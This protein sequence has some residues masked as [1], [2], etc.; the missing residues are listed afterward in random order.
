MTLSLAG[1]WHYSVEDLPDFA[2]PGFSDS[3]WQTMR[4]P[5]NWFLGGLDHH[6]VVW[7][8]H[9]FNFKPSE[10]YTSLHFDGVDYFADV[11][12]NGSHLGHHTGYFERFSFDVTDLLRTGKNILAV[13]VNSPYEQLGQDG[14]HIRKRLIKGVLNHHDCRPGGG[15]NPDGQSYNTGGIWNN[16]YLEGH[17]A[18]T[19]E[20]V[21]LH[22]ELDVKPPVLH[23]KLTAKNRSGEQ[24]ADLEVHCAPENFKGNV[25]AS[26]FALEIPAGE[27]VHSVQLPIPDAQLWQ[28]WDRGYPHLYQITTTLTA[29]REKAVTTSLFGFRTVKLEQGFHWE[30]NG[31]PYFIRGSNYIGSQWLSET[32]FSEAATS[33]T[34]P[35]GGGAGGDF[36]RRDVELAR[37]ANLNMLRVHAHVLPP[38]FHDACDRAGI[39][40]W[41]D[42]PLQWGYSDQA[43]F[44][45]EAEREMRLMVTQLYNHPSIAAW[46]CHN[47]SP[48][49]APWMA[50]AVGGTYDP[51]QN[52]DLDTHLQAIAMELDP[53]RHVH[54]SSGTGDGHTYPG[55]YHGHWRD[56][57]D[58]P[59]APFI[60]EYGAQ[61]LPVKESLQRMLPQFESDA[62]FA[63]LLRLKSWIE[64]NKKISPSTRLFIKFGFALFKFMENRPS[65][66]RYRESFMEWAMKRGQTAERSIYQ[67]LPSLEEIPADLQPARQVWQAWQFHNT[68][69]METFENG[70]KTGTSLDDF[71]FN[72]QTYQAHVI[73]FGTECYRRAKCSKVTGI[74]QFDFTD[75]WP[76]VTW[77]VLDYWRHP[78]A[79]FDALRR[80]MQPVLPS[81]Q[82]PEKIDSGKAILASFCA[83]N[84]LVEAFP[85]TLCEWLLFNDKGDIASASFALD[86]PADGVSSVVKLTLPS[87]TLGKYTLSVSLTIGNRILGENW[88]EI[89]VDNLER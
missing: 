83:V 25:L 37:Q 2:N 68:Q 19:I 35:F 30:I 86:I 62:G 11:Y 67:N 41:Q 31:K 16:V 89:L 84:D 6:G 7:F 13:R 51:S 80:S 77:S 72:S 8:R 79:S 50:G 4:I 42:F 17:G 45:A 82:L 61:G 88:Y 60:S 20:Q 75:P 74:L 1:N 39:L 46:C 49:D 63:D 40:V 36:Y 59:G 14:W 48:W 33:K 69:L 65:L 21:L 43:D 58:L 3:A 18:V 76:A 53:G 55:W 54:L 71:I 28:P 64:S 78:K 81:F 56:Y 26:K 9:E 52:R 34:H 15:W 44:Q 85:G 32:L 66:K 23:I 70:I 29:A 73:Q 10:D 57:Q 22:S 5:Q 47:E 27:S 38:E 12:L 87:L 24:A